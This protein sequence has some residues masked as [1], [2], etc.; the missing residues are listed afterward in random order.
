MK[1]GFFLLE[2]ESIIVC[3]AE[4]YTFIDHLIWLAPHIFFLFLSLYNNENDGIKLCFHGNS[5]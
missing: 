5:S 3:K 1:V 2:I 4:K